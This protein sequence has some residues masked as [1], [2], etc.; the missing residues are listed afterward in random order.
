[1]R[2]LVR[3]CGTFMEAVEADHALNSTT[4]LAAAGVAACAATAGGGLAGSR[5]G[6]A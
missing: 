4:R 1:M 6:V 5:Q 2:E 3:A